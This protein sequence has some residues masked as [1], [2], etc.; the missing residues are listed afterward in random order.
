MKNLVLFTQCY[1]RELAYLSKL[2]QSIC[3]FEPTVDF[4]VILIDKLA[5]TSN[6][7]FE[8]IP[9]S[10]MKIAVFEELSKKYNWI[11]LKNN[12]KPFVIEKLLT[13]YEQV[14]YLESTTQLHQP[15]S[16]LKESLES[17]NAFLVPQLLN[18]NQHKKEN[19]ALNLGI[20]HTGLMGF[21]RSEETVRFLK[22][23]QQH[24]LHKGF[25]NPCVGMNT[26]RLCLELAPIFFKNT[27]VLKHQGLNLGYWNKDD[28]KINPTAII[29]SNTELKINYNRSP[30]PAYGLFAKEYSSTQ[31]KLRSVLNFTIRQIDAFFDSF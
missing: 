21:N 30:K 2:H 3:T 20:Y 18:A 1:T 26:D 29:T 5:D 31:R 14:I 8:I 22:W 9:I 4:K 7:P 10:S 13:Q 19:N 6:Y 23:W 15:L 17:K 11:E 12:C 28:R 27:A 16:V 25:Y 24:T